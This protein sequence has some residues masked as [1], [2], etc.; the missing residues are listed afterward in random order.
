PINGRVTILASMLGEESFIDSVPSNGF[1]DTGETFFDM[2]EAFRDDDEDGFYTVFVD[3]FVDF[4]SDGQYTE[5]DGLY[6]GILCT[7]STLCSSEK[8]IHVRASQVLVM[9]MDDFIVEVSKDELTSTGN[10]L[11]SLT[12]TV[13]SI[14]PDGSHQTPPGGTIISA[15]ATIGDLI[16]FDETAIPCTND[17]EFDWSVQ[18]AG[19]DVDEVKTGFLKIIV[20]SPSGIAVQKTVGLTANP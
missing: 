17:G 9:A 6:N 5:S 3:E 20:T 13:Y 14:F 7:S 11:D 12:V 19:G 4:N 1:L 10:S 16:S 2:P 8:N 18:W 15:E